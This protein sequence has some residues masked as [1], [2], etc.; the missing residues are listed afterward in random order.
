MVG[1]YQGLAT[2]AQQGSIG[3]VHPDTHRKRGRPIRT[4]SGRPQEFLWTETTQLE[5]PLIPLLGDIPGFNPA[6]QLPIPPLPTA[7]VG[8]TV[9]LLLG[10]TDYPVLGSWYPGMIQ[11]PLLP[12]REWESTWLHLHARAVV[13]AHPAV[14][15]AL[16]LGQSI[17]TPGCRCF[18]RPSPPA[19]AQ[20]QTR[21][22]VWTTRDSPPRWPTNEIRNL[23]AAGLALHRQAVVH[24]DRQPEQPRR[25][26][27]SSGSAGPLSPGLALLFNGATPPERALPQIQVFT[28]QYD[29]VSRLPGV[30]AER[31]ERTPTPV[32]RVPVRRRHDYAP[33]AP[34]TTPIQLAYIARLHREH[35]LV[36][37]RP[38]LGI[39]RCLTPLR[40]FVPAPFGNALADLL[41][42]DLRVIVDMGYGSGEYPDLPTPARL[43]E[44]PNP[45]T[46][47]P[48]LAAGAIQGPQ[49]A[50]VDLGLLPQSMLPNAYP[51]L[52][53]AESRPELQSGSVRHDGLVAA[54]GR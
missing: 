7:P 17:A 21:C 2:Q 11:W 12:G 49:A 41:Q 9:A 26:H 54:D 35:H 24:P 52:P 8:Q 23:M 32:F 15:R 46:I 10:G 50:L 33:Y 45:S 31:G 13:A 40:E 29:G 30:P 20:W 42:P 39:C 51:Y 14:R 25:G 48:D 36:H 22:L 3:L 27:G 47:I 19:V 4:P 16:T 37:V 44:I 38:R 34:Y 53:G 43:I 6:S 1:G 28:N 5:Q 18:T